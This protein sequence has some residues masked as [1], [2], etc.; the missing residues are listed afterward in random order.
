VSDDQRRL[1]LAG[2]IQAELELHRAQLGMIAIQSG[3]SGRT[4]RR[5][6]NGHQPNIRRDNADRVAIAIGTH[7][8]TLYGPAS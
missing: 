2:P 4:L 1:L 5:I 8:T 6:V 3:V 7:I